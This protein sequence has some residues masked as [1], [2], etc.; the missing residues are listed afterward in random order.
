VIKKKGG[1]EVEM[2]VVGQIRSDYLRCVM[3]WLPPAHVTQGRFTIM[4]HTVNQL[5]SRA[6]HQRA[7]A[8]KQN[9]NAMKMNIKNRQEPA[10]FT[11]SLRIGNHN[12]PSQQ[13]DTDSLYHCLLA[14][15]LRPL[16]EKHHV[17]TH[18]R[19]LR[20][21]YPPPL[22]LHYFSSKKEKKGI[23]ESKKRT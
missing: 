19:T 1:L 15:P 20:L 14:L 22:L 13:K 3:P 6:D 21:C 18:A 17:N 23:S 4:H 5:R 8:I 16:H 12:P 11:A 10:R 9:E 7:S 2:V